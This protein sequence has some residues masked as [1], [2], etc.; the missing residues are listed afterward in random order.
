ML[1]FLTI[2]LTSVPV[3]LLAALLFRAAEQPRPPAAAPVLDLPP[4]RFFADDLAAQIAA[5]RRARALAVAQIEHH[6]RLEQAAAEEFLS[7]PT[8]EGLHA[9]TAS[10]LLN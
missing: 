7:V 2:L 5:G 10:P 8:L 9:Q 3:L 4:A 6:V 1:M